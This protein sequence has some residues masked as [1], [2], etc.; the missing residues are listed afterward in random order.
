MSSRSRSTQHA[1][2]GCADCTGVLPLGRR[3]REDVQAICLTF[4]EQVLEALPGCGRR[5]LP[6]LFPTANVAVETSLH[7]RDVLAEGAQ[8]SRRQVHPGGRAS[9]AQHIPS[10]CW[11]ARPAAIGTIC[12]DNSCPPMVL[13]Q[14]QGCSRGLC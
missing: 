10:R 1:H 12:T 14:K 6:R 7:I 4:A 13:Q 9:S 5:D 3:T 11:W 2:K 8:Y